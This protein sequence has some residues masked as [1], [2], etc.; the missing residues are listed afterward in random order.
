MSTRSMSFGYVVWANFPFREEYIA[1]R[2]L[3]MVLADLG[4]SFIGA[5]VTTNQELLSGI[6][7]GTVI[8]AQTSVL[9]PK[10]W[11]VISKSEVYWTSEHNGAVGRINL[12]KQREASLIVRQVL[13]LSRLPEDEG[14]Y[15]RFGQVIFQQLT[16]AA[17]YA[18]AAIKQRELACTTKRPS[19]PKTANSSRPSVRSF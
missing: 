11:A 6:N 16:I 15:G 17:T 18:T 5:Y 13:Q 19:P 10:R 14:G 3:V 12:S 1:K 4:D 7:V 9:V 8:E 2:R